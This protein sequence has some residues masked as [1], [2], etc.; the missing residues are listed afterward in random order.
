MRTNN[1]KEEDLYIR[2]LK[3]AYEQDYF[4]YS[5]L[6]EALGISA[7]SHDDRKLIEH[8]GRRSLLYIDT[9]TIDSHGSKPIEKFLT[10]NPDER[11]LAISLDD[12]FK[13]LE[14]T[15]LEEARASS[16]TATRFAGWALTISAISTMSS[17]I[18]NVISL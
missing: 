8:I 11:V 1:H 18:F 15:E 10:R 7:G 9:S 13:L 3:W 6:R 17:I 5:Q 2:V 12:R 14:Y 4:T 16:R